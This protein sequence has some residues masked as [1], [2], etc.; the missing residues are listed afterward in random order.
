M[1]C[2]RRED[3]EHSETHIGEAPL[4]PNHTSSVSSEKEKRESAIP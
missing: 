3:T 2:D 4:L 1:L